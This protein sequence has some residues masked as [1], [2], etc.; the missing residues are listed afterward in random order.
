MAVFSGHSIGLEGD[1]PERKKG[2][3]PGVD[4][5]ELDGHASSK[6]RLA[7]GRGLAREAEGCGLGTAA[8]PEFLKTVFSDP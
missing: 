3:L 6:P 7:N 4:R 8:Q 2:G 1:R 5:P